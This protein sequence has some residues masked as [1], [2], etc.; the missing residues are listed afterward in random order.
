[1]DAFFALV[2]T[3][4]GKTMVQLYTNDIQFTKIYPMKTKSETSDML[5]SL[6]HHIEIP[7]SI[8]SDYTKEYIQGKFWKLCSEYHIPFTT[9]KPY[10]PYWQNCAEGAIC[11]LKRRVQ[12]KMHSRA[13]PQSLWDYCCKSSADIRSKTAHKIPKW[14]DKHPMSLSWERPLTYHP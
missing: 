5:L 7:A 8:H 14:K 9:T 6:L 12:C 11:E 2:P 4:S 3:T 1:M 13:V 10:S